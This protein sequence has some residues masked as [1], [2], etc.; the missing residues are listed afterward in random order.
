MEI[1]AK[2]VKELRDRTGAGLMDC[3]K[4]L[5][6]C[7]GD[8]DAAGKY[9]REK[10]LAAM[11]KRSDRVTAE[12]RIFSKVEGNKVAMIE[13]LCETDF[14][15]K[16]ADFIAAGEKLVA[17]TFEKELN[18]VTEE[19]KAILSELAIKI[20]ENMSVGKIVCF[21]APSDCAISTYVH[22]TFKIGSIVTIKGSTDERVAKAAHLY[23]LHMASKMPK[24]ITKSD[25]PES[26]IAE[27]TEILK[28][29]MAQDESLNG[30][31]EKVLAGILQGKI[32]KLV[33]ECYFL[34]QPY[35]DNEKITVE[36]SLAALS[37]E[38]GA[39]LTFDKVILFVLGK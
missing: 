25:V 39:Q 26:Y 24:Y 33:N 36:A 2:D 8:I 23:C 34:A 7:N 9:L 4:A 6:E 13:V 14:V 18:E 5:S 27:Q 15:A 30:K 11:A 1:S 16:S 28:A 3:K 10:G 38:V 35:I 37:K 21:T 20:R 19:H 31:P 32:N 12:G 29:N 17:L 22:H